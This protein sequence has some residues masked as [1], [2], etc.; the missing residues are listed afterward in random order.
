MNLILLLLVALLL[1]RRGARSSCW[2]CRSWP[3]RRARWPSSS[4]PATGSSDRW[5][6]GG[7]G[8]RAP[9]PPDLPVPDVGVLP[10]RRAG[11]RARCCSPTGRPG[12]N[13]GDGSRWRRCWPWPAR[14]TWPSRSCVM[15]VLIVLPGRPPHRRH[16]RRGRRWPGS[17]WPP[18]DPPVD[19]TGSRPST[20][21]SSASSA[22][23]TEVVRHV[24]SPS[25]GM[26]YDT[27]TAPGPHELLPDD[28]RAGGVPPP[29]RP[30]ARCSSPVPMLAINVLS[31][32]P[33]QR[34]IRVSTTRP[35]C[36]SASSWP[37]WRPSPTSAARPRPAPV[38]RRA[39]AGD[40]VGGHR[41][42]GAVAGQRE[43]PQR[44]LAARAPIPGGRP[45]E[46]AVGH[47]P[48]ARRRPAPSTTCAPHL[49]HRTKIY[50]FPDPW[51]A[52]NWGVNGEN[53]DDPAD[54]E[55]LVLDRTPAQRRRQG[56]GRPTPDG[57]VRHPLRP[58]RHHASP[59]G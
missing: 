17:P 58:E 32:F 9:A 5:L 12:P 29:R 10:P 33:Y 31:T 16:H 36:W 24:C 53:L 54:V 21:P 11:H 39:G 23:P 49:T 52:V 19:A 56:P 2:W 30:V 42:L 59:N 14:R 55:W 25:P 4:W 44:L 1:A 22:S 6:G 50:E 8:Q 7:P 20:T 3:R 57:G 28:V 51:K 45:S 48:A 41:R 47:G 18:S 38:P 15:G 40:V 26:A 27:A 46:A 43:V 13:G 35:W 37:R 34:E